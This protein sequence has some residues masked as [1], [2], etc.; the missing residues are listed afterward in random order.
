MRFGGARSSGYLELIHQESEEG[1]VLVAGYAGRAEVD[2]VNVGADDP[3]G[4]V[5]DSAR[6]TTAHVAAAFAASVVCS[7]SAWFISGSAAGSQKREPFLVAAR[8]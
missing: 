7:L 2:A 3:W 1:V 8:S 5:G 6:S 4:G